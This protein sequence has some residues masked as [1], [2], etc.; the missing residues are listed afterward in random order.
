MTWYSNVSVQKKVSNT[1]NYLFTLVNIYA[2]VQLFALK[3][4]TDLTIHRMDRYKFDTQLLIARLNSFYLRSL[5][6]SSGHSLFG[7]VFLLQLMKKK[8]LT[9]SYLQIRGSFCS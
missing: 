6:F 5:N 9:N 7:F 4:L 2:T 1:L 3:P 8:K